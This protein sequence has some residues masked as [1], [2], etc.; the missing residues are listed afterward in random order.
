MY[1]RSCVLHCVTREP[2]ALSCIFRIANI[3]GIWSTGV[4]L[5]HGR[6]WRTS[7]VGNGMVSLV[8]LLLSLVVC[9]MTW[10]LPDSGG[11]ITVTPA[12]RRHSS[13]V[14]ILRQRFPAGVCDTC[15]AADRG[16]L[17]WRCR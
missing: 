7:G 8:R 1:A 15:F 17:W 13:A 16:D 5:H 14:V 4:D 12:S 6:C 9:P 3:P 10:A 2:A 11:G